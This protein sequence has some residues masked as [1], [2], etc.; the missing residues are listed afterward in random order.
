MAAS[1]GEGFLFQAAAYLGAAAIAVPVFRRLKLGAILGYLAA[2]V[3]LGPS[4]LHIAEAEEGVFHVA[5]LGVVL[6]LFL[7]GL[8]LSLGRLWALRREIFGLGASQMLVTGLLIAGVMHEFGLAWAPALIGGYA[9]ACSSTAFA[10]QLLQERGEFHAPHGRASFAVLLFQDIAVVPLVA[11]IPFVAAAGGETAGLLDAAKAAG[12]VVALV[13]IGRYALNPAFRIVARSGS[14][15]AFAAAALFV[16]S[17]TALAVDWAGLSMA[18]GAFLAGVLLAESSFRHQIETDIE[19]F[20]GLLLGLFFIGV[21]MQL[22]LALVMRQWWIV[23]GGALGLV[24]FKALAF[25]VVARVFRISHPAGL[26]A[27]A[28]LSQ[29][30]EFAFVV[31]SIGG[32]AGLFTVNATTLLSAIVTVSMATTPVLA[33]LAARIAAPRKRESDDADLD[34]P[35]EEEMGAQAI[36][37][38]FGRMGQIIAQVLKNSGV[39][40]TAIDRDPDRIRSAERFGFKVYFGDGTRLDL[41]MN[42][43]AVQADIVILAIDDEEAVRRAAERLREKYPQV[44]IFAR[45][46]ERMS[47]VALLDLDLDLIVRDTLESSIKLARHSLLALGFGENAATAIIEEFRKRDRERLFLQRSEG[48]EGGMNILHRPFAAAEEDRGR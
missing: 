13:L 48:V 12:V 20:R 46:R 27:A 39:T 43:G 42:A 29:G 4:G 5:E 7:I 26:R 36:I 31:L 18:L 37:V 2:G 25:Y 14:R 38:G 44:K 11:A 34:G 32:A 30:G 15:E 22:D 17:A 19:P 45:A 9:L 47:E 28:T 35:S 10:L 24:A 33:T 21:G 41:L 3:A 6:F 1:G 8:E 23:I 16:V 40:V